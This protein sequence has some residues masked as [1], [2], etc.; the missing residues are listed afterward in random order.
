MSTG[1]EILRADAGT[2]E[3]AAR[4]ARTLEGMGLV[5]MPT[6]T[7]YG[8][9]ASLDSPCALEHIFEAKRRPREMPVPVLIASA[10]D[11][12]RLTREPLSGK[13]GRASCRERV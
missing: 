12:D 5:V 8:L 3:I 11:A 10:A 1:P 6:D 9:A 7:V 4:A 2:D 13:I